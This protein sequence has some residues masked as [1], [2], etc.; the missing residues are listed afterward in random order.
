MVTKTYLCD[1]SDS[2]DKKNSF[3]KTKMLEEIEKLED[4]KICDKKNLKTQN[5]FVNKKILEIR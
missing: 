4:L 1:S 2:C 3:T 5:Y